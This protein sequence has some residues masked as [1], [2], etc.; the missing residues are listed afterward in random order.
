MINR[1]VNFSVFFIT[2]TFM[3]YSTK[4]QERFTK[5][6]FYIAII[7]TY[8]PAS[9]TFYVKFGLTHSVS[10]RLKMFRFRYLLKEN[11]MLK[12]TCKQNEGCVWLHFG[13]SLYVSLNILQFDTE[14]YN[15]SVI[16]FIK[17]WKHAE[18]I[19]RFYIII[20]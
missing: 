15:L 1:N 14:Q 19:S 20:F 8:L 12:K 7:Q 11:G 13:A 6:I 16:L 10:A 18:N 2:C 4:W 5:I 9:H 3:V 17:N